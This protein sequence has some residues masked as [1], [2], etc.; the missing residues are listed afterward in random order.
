M[1]F[2]C[3]T[4]WKVSQSK[5]VQNW[6]IELTSSNFGRHPYRSR[7]ALPI[8]D[9]LLGFPSVVASS[10]HYKAEASSPALII[11]NGIYPSWHHQHNH[12]YQVYHWSPYS[13]GRQLNTNSNI[14]LQSY[15]FIHLSSLPFPYHY[16]YFY[17]NGHSSIL[18]PVPALIDRKCSP[19]WNPFLCRAMIKS[20]LMLNN[21]K[22][23]FLFT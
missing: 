1:P 19:L 21:R 15:L 23:T 10:F 3:L 5:W 22:I 9:L 11:L 2:V 7:P 13:T 12:N 4:H 14:V 17:L 20:M 8:F 18:P 6:S 16:H